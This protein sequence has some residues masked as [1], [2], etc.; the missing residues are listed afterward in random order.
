MHVAGP[1]ASLLL[2]LECRRPVKDTA[3][4][5]RRRLFVASCA[6]LV[7][8]AIAF[9]VCTDIMG[10]FERAF[11]LNKGE[12]GAAVSWG[13]IAGTALQFLGGALLDFVG[14]GNALW[15][16][17]AA[18]LSG[19]TM[20]IFAQ[21][22]WTLAL[23]WMFMAVAGGLVEASVNPLAATMYPGKKTHVMN[24]LHAWWPGGLV[25]G[26]LLAYG[27]TVLLR[28]AGASQ[29]IQDRSWQIKMAFAYVPVVL[30][31]VLI[32]GQKFP[33]TERVQAGV[34]AGAMFREVLRPGFLLLVCCMFLTASVELGP[35]RW[36]GV[37][38]EDILGASRWIKVSSERVVEVR[39]V[40]VLAYVSVLMFV[41]RF[42]AG[43]LAKRISP[44]GILIASCIPAGV[45]MLWLS[46]AGDTLTFFLAATV[47][48]VGVTYFWPTMLG[49]TAERFPMG[50]AF[51]LAVIGAL[52]G[53]FNSYVTVP[54]MGLLHDQYTLKGLPDPVAR[55]VVVNDRVDKALEG[56]LSEQEKAEL[57]RVRG[58]AA[59]TTFRYV[60]AMTPVLF[61]LFGVV[62]LRN[63]MGA[64]RDSGTIARG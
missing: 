8:N 53:L 29:A 60:A 43:P 23:G 16:A 20:I 24:V 13:A 47:W 49:V 37:F 36:I 56:K 40:L 4:D 14:I 22:F 31:A 34:P 58:T 17:C 51:L 30:Y 39:G 54:G 2:P 6:A 11:K 28:E 62:I 63:R 5:N 25:I 59:S 41:L 21:G 42:F 61:I 19:V 48:A 33:K 46:Y 32:L 38:T 12:A 50:G 9:S 3:L 10:D 1:S 18:H 7:A 44:M 64:R 26:S 55:K 27:L 15:L 35:N 57:D 45:G 52:G